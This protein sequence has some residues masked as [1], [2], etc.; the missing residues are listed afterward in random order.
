MLGLSEKT[1]I[2]FIG[3]GGIGM[4]GIAEVLL[5]L[6]HRVSG[7][8]LHAGPITDHLASKGAEI[9]IGHAAGNLNGVTIVVYSTA[10]DNANPEIM[11]AK[12]EKIPIVRRAEMLAE[13]MRLKK[14]VAIA[15]S[16]GKTTTTSMVATIF[17]EAGL[18]PTHI[19]GGIVSNLGGN[20]RK[21][22]GEFL[23]AEADESDGS[24]LLLSPVMAV[25]TNIDNDHL[26]FHKT[27]ANI[28]LAFVEFINKLPFFG[29]VALNAQDPGI[30]MIMD[31]IKRPYVLFG[32]A[33]KNSALLDYAVKDVAYAPGKT[34]FEVLHKGESLGMIETRVSGEHNVLN[35][36]AAIA[37]CHEAGIGFSQ[38]ASGIR[39]F[40]GVGRRLESLWKQGHFEVIDDYGHH[41]TEIR[42]TLKTVKDVYRKPVCVVFEPHR[43]SR[44]Q[45]L[46]DDFLTC[47][48]LADEVFIAPIY[49]ASEKPIDGITAKKL[50]EALQGRRQRISYISS[51]ASM[52]EMIEER[53]ASD[54]VFLTLGAGSISKTIKS[55]VKAL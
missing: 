10:I 38:I 32:M 22:N 20:A 21:G 18:D 24:F 15:G 33:N 28:R 27:E 36:A 41:P 7:S 6:G 48:D 45:Q 49:A 34:V 51:L 3:I 52:K 39:Q 12:E 13:L 4:S 31:Q 40:V 42:A 14:G 35:A 47:F 46:W 17:H 23:I 55:I 26:D 25:V 5:D 53:R 2:H 30:Q 54:M 50:V 44:T 16:H 37:I 43:Y 29:R 9:H 19:I 1:K 11:R 8:D